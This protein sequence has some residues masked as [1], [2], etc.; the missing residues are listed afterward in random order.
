MSKCSKYWMDLQP[1][2][3][4]VLNGIH[5]CPNCICILIQT[6]QDKLWDTNILRDDEYTYVLSKAMLIRFL[7]LNL[8]KSSIL[9]LKKNILIVGIYTMSFYDDEGIDY[10]QSLKLYQITVW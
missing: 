8:T 7:N 6:E 9:S 3:D 1:C 5:Y 10:N 2:I 4:I